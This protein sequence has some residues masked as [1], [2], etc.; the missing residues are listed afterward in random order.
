ARL[1]RLRRLLDP[2]EGVPRALLDL[3]RDRARANLQEPAERDVPR[4]LQL[5]ARL[6]VMRGDRDDL[7]PPHRAFEDLVDDPQ[8]RMEVHLLPLA[9][10]PERE[11]H[12]AVNDVP[13]ASQGPDRK[14]PLPELR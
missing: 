14:G 7:C 6:L 11:G 12:L 4:R 2:L 9:G 1:R 10:A 8:R 3:S 13:R 5:D